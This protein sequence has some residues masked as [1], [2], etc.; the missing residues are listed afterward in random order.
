MNQATTIRR[1]TPQRTADALRAEPTPTIEPVMVWVVETGMS[2][3]VARNRV[4]A[5]PV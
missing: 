2:K 3:R 4:I 5:P 1:A